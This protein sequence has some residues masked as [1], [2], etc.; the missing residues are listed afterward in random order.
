MRGLLPDFA[1]E[2][3]VDSTTISTYANPHHNSD[4][5][6]TWTRKPNS[7]HKLAWHYGYRLHLIT[8]AR[9]EIPVYADVMTANLND[10]PTLVPLVSASVEA[11]GLRPF[12]V[13][14]DAGYDSNANVEGMIALGARPVIKRVNRIVKTGA[15]R[16]MTARLM[17]DQEAREWVEAYNKRTSVERVFARLKGHRGLTRHSRRRLLPVTLH[18]LLA[19]LTVQ[20]SALGQV[21][22]GGSLRQCARRVA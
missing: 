1:D 15:Y 12:I 21:S 16:T 18:C 2:L 11:N 9:H 7:Q 22:V 5:D 19:V 4:P 14:A 20:A 13:S 8:D 6:A 3:A 10:S 17:V